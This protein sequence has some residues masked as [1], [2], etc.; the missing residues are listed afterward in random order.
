MPRVLAHYVRHLGAISLERAVAQMSAAAANELFAH[1][2]GR[3]A[4][5]LAADLVLFDAERVEDRASFAE[6]TTVSVGIK[7]VLVNGQVVLES[8][9]YTGAKPGKVLRGPGD[10][11][12]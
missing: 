2:R 12:R 7:Y 3:I 5:G 1:D 11:R 4:E 10:H 8:G 9:T 6:P